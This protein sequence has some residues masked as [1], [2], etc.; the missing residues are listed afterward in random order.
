MKWAKKMLDN[1]QCL[2]YVVLL[3]LIRRAIQLREGNLFIGDLLMGPVKVLIVDD[4]PLFAQ[5]TQ[6][7][8]STF[9][10]ESKVA[11]NGI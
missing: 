9:G 6:Q 1:P 2:D 8:L 11:R 7:Q 10:L 4:D 5:T 3:F